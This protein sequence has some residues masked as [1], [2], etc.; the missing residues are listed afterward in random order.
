M[1]RNEFLFCLM[2]RK[3]GHHFTK[4]NMLVPWLLILLTKSPDKIWIKQF[5]MEIFVWCWS[6]WVAFVAQKWHTLCSW[7]VLSSNPAKPSIFILI[8]SI[9]SVSSFLISFLCKGATLQKF[10][11]K[12]FSLAVGSFLFM[13]GEQKS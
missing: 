5:C 8:F 4:N 1:S 11:K 12:R 2:S 3:I 6:S 10:F 7:Q 9:S 13:I